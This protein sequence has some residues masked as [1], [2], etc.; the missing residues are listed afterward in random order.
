[1]LEPYAGASPYSHAGQRV[2]VGQRLM[3]AASDLFL[4]WYTT[5]ASTKNQFFIRQLR[6]AKIKPVV[7]IMK[8]ANLMGYARLCG[9]A[10]ARAHTRSGDAAVLAGIMGKGT[11]FENAMS[12]FGLVY[13]DQNERDHAAL[14]EAIGSGRI[15]ARTGE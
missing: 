3:K 6:D 13:A 11:A 1:M 15:E 2:V 9:Q 8:P 14:L 7:E 10:L 4:G 5:T 12:E